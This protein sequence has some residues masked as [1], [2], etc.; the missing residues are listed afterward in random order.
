MSEEQRVFEVKL[1][2]NLNY[3]FNIHFGDNIP[4]LVT[5][6]PQPLGNSIGPN[7]S[8]LLAAAIGNC[9]S[10][11]LLFCLQKAR[12]PVKGM[13]TLVKGTTVR[14]ERGRL[15]IIEFNVEISPEYE[16]GH[17]NQNNR[18]SELFEDFCIVSK[19]VE[20]GIP[21]KVRVVKS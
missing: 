20:Q 4:N 3:I 10:S 16:I 17:E 12:A 9:L 2:H 5:D 15:R 13:K 14:N 21:I 18:C 11:S 19:S 1:E 8:R 6:E 7:P